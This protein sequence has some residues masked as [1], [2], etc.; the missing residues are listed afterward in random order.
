MRGHL[1]V[2][3]VQVAS[4]RAGP[5]LD[6]RRVALAVE[7]DRRRRGGGRRRTLSQVVVES[8]G[9]YAPV[10]VQDRVGGAV[11]G[12]DGHPPSRITRLGHDGP[13]HGGEGREATGHRA[14]QQRGE[15][16]PVG[17]PGGVDPRRV[18]ALVRL[19]LVEHGPHEVDVVVGVGARCGSD[20]PTDR[21]PRAF[22]EHHDEPVAPCRGVELGGHR[23][24]GGPFGEA[25]EVDDDGE[26]SGPGAGRWPREEVP[27][28]HPVDG[29]VRPLVGHR[30]RGAARG[31]AGSGACRARHRRSR[32]RPGAGR[33][34][35]GGARAGPVGGAG[36]GHDRQHHDDG[37]PAASSGAL[38]HWAK[39]STSPV[40]PSSS[41]GRPGR[42]CGEGPDPGRTG[43]GM[44]TR[45]P[46][47][48]FPSRSQRFPRQARG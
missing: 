24:E 29:D 37:G 26:G 39:Q 2:G 22:G 5:G 43:A 34:G 19:Q 38:P 11:E 20:V 23:L 41:A 21:G 14:R 15:Q 48:R 45:A 17:E 10:E 27:P 40:E 33:P 31:G 12:H 16:R 13:G 32:A 30:G 9:T 36:G 35:G 7:I 25:V 46:G 47:Q 1:G 6:V 8:G 42:A 28:R 44:G 3:R 4:V 18:D